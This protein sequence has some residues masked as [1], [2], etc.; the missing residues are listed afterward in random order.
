MVGTDRSPGARFWR[1]IRQLV[2]PD[3]VRQFD[4]A[5][6]EDVSDAW[7]DLTAEEQLDVMAVLRAASQGHRVVVARGG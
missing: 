3:D 1:T 5:L 6:L 4:Q 2:D 7:D